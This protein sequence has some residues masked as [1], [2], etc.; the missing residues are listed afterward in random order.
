[1]LSRVNPSETYPQVLCLSPTF[2]LAKQTGS[3]LEKMAQF[4]PEI[5]MGYAL[6][7]EKGGLKGCGVGVVCS[8]LVFLMLSFGRV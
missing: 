3:V 8:W 7:E 2:D 6:R 1:M 5:K 4:C